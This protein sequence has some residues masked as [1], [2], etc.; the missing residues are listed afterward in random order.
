MQIQFSTISISN[1]Y[2]AEKGRI[3][4]LTFSEYL[5]ILIQIIRGIHTNCHVI[6]AFRLPWNRD[7]KSHPLSRKAD[8]CLVS[9]NDALSQS[10]GQPNP[11]GRAIQF[12][13]PIKT[14]YL[15]PIMECVAWRFLFVRYIFQGRRAEGVLFQ[16]ELNVHPPLCNPHCL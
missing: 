2:R 14:N 11:Q 12:S 5:G 6:P 13:A 10:H 16:T 3:D 7:G 15:E 4:S 8:H 1:E 9:S